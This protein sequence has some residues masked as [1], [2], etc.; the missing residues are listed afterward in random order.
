MKLSKG[1][2]MA[3]IAVLFIGIAAYIVYAMVTPDKNL[4][5]ERCSDLVINIEGADDAAFLTQKSIED[6]LHRASIHPKG[7][8]LKDVSAKKIIETLRQQNQ[9]VSDINCYKTANGKVVIDVIQRTPVLYILPDSKSGYYVDG[10]GNVIKNTDYPANILVATGR[11]TEKFATTCLCY[12]GA[13]ISDDEFLDNLI[14]QIYVS[15]STDGH[16]DINLVP[17]IGQQQIH[18]GNISN[19]AKKL[20]RLKKF[21]QNA[22]TSVGWNKY[23]TIDLEYDNQI[24]CKK[25]K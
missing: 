19:Y 4:S 8:L 10:D 14:E 21:Y 23:S 5:D 12:L 9:F 25:I 18:L 11:I 22:L 6:Q 7:Q 2:Q 24:I 15:R 3:V 1:I 20:E 16:F 17:R 13:Y